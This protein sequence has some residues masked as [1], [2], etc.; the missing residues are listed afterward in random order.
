[1][2]PPTVCRNFSRISHPH[3]LLVAL[4]ALMCV[5]CASGEEVRLSAEEIYNTALA[6]YEDNAFQEAQVNF[7][8][9]IEQNP[10]TRLATVSYLKLGDLYLKRAEWDKS[11]TNYQ[12]FLSLSPNSHLV[13]YVLK[14]LI[15]LNYERNHESLFFQDQDFNMEPNRKIIQEYQRFFFLY[16]QNAYLSDVKEF[17]QEAKH[18]LANHEFSVGNFYFNNKAFDAAIL[19]Y[20]YL[21]KT[22]SA[23]PRT[24]EVGSRLVQAYEANQQPHLAQ[25]MKKA[26][27]VRFSHASLHE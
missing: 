7:E 9:V 12:T 3:K 4:L 8:K 22:Y 26:I 10:G 16:P 15:E 23:Y 19:R 25:E 18:D 27:E 17:L 13:P 1:M 6:D 20:L 5:G 14:Q 21:L 2:H 11:E 24:K